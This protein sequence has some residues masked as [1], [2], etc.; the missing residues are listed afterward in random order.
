MKTSAFN[1]ATGLPT[2]RRRDLRYRI[3]GRVVLFSWRSIHEKG[4]K[5]EGIALDISPQ[6]AF[7]RSFASPPVGA[8]VEIEM[9][10]SF[11]STELRITGEARVIRVFSPSENDRA[12]A[13]AVLR[14]GSNQWDHRLR[15]TAKPNSGVEYLALSRS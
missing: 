1:C 3:D 8:L 2:E 13:F 6:G 5:A 14:V 9:A 10:L 12:I 4:F 11:G 15:T 7:I